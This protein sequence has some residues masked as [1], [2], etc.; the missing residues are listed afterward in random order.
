MIDLGFRDI[1]DSTVAKLLKE[2][3][4]NNDGVVDWGEFL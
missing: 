4:L 2:V 1:N 3:D